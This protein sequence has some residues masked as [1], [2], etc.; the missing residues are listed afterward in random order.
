MKNTKPGPAKGHPG[1][2]GRPRG[3]EMPCGWGCGAQLTA[4]EIR[5]HFTSCPRRPDLRSRERGGPAMSV[6][7]RRSSSRAHGPQ[8]ESQ[9]DFLERLRSRAFD[10]LKQTEAIGR[11]P[12]GS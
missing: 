3:V 9:T 7:V 12:L 1:W 10:A 4:A 6:S 8:S 5:T 11:G 2:G